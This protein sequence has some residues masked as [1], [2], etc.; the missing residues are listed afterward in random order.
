MTAEER[1]IEVLKA[2]VAAF[3]VG[4]LEGTSTE[5]IARRA[6]ISQPYLFRLYPTKKALFIAAVETAFERI[7]RAL[8]VAAKDLD[9]QA[10]L[11]AIAAEYALLLQDRELLLVQMQAYAACADPEIRAAARRCFRRL[12]STI[13]G[14]SGIGGERLTM[15]V[16]VGMLLNV[17]ASLELD[18]VGQEWAQ[19]CTKVPP[20]WLEAPE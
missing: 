4:G 3:A 13:A 18:E 5:D 10:A 14:L 17:A 6:G 12:W 19:L 11:E 9:D 16:A 15:F 2:A 8:E 1:R 20:S 7:N